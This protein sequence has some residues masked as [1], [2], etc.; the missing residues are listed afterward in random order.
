M[1]LFYYFSI[2]QFR[3][4]AIWTSDGQNRATIMEIGMKLK[5]RLNLPEKLIISYQ[6]HNDTMVKSGSTVKSQFNI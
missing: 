2:N 6:L 4:V 5:Q 3:I 1:Q